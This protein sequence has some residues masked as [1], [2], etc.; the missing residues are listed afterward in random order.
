MSDEWNTVNMKSGKGGVLREIEVLR[1]QYADH[2]STLER[3]AEDAP[4]ENLA[5]RYRELV[6]ELEDS[7]ARIAD[8]EMGVAS[9]SSEIPSDDERFEP[10]PYR[11]REE[12]RDRESSSPGGLRTLFIVLAGIFMIAVLG[13]LLWNWAFDGA[14]SIDAP[15]RIAENETVAPP[16]PEPPPVE[17]EPE[18]EVTPTVQEY[19]ALRRGAR[20]ARQF[21]VVNN[22]DATLPIQV[23]RSDCRCL[24]FEY[25]DT[26]P[27]RGTTTLTVT[28]DG[29]KAPVGALRETVRIATR[30]EPPMTTTLEVRAAIGETQ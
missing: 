28:V 23:E 29:A 15:D 20:A 7:M 30:T 24:W 12:P 21:E 14:D 25:A 13:L 19:G 3:L 8:L 6:R 9:G 26:I 16:L 17:A 18:L 10:E 22:T 2:R 1:K 27:P 11:G 5:K 4:T